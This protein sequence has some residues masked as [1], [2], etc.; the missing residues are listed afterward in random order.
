MDFASVILELAWNMEQR[1][2]LSKMI[3]DKIL[4]AK[5]SKFIDQVQAF[6]KFFADY[7]NRHGETPSVKEAE[8]Y[9]QAV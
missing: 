6:A 8:K 3:D 2:I 7:F 9:M 4:N 1:A 5:S